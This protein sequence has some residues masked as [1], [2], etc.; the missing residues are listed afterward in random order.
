M[1]NTK[2]YDFVKPLQ[3]RLGLGRILGVGILLAEGDE[4]KVSPTHQLTPP[5]PKPYLLTILQ[6]SVN[7][8]T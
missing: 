6:N 7:A 2:S 3:I 8:S 5:T 1:L 4:H